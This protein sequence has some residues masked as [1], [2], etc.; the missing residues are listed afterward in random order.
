M[1]T[2]LEA[3]LKNKKSSRMP[4][5]FV[6]HGSPMNIVAD[7]EYTRSLSRFALSLPKPKSILIISAH[8]ETEGSFVQASSRPTIIHDF[9]GFP[10]SLYQTGYESEGAPQLASVLEEQLK[11][12]VSATTNWGLDH[13]AW[14]VLYHMYPEGEIPVSQI[15]LNVN[16][17]FSQHYQLAQELIHLR[18]QEVLII[19]SGNIV[20][21]LRTIQWQED[22]PTADWAQDFDLRVAEA[23]QSGQYE[24]FLAPENMGGADLF[25]K[26]H[27][28]LDHYIPLLYSL[29]ARTEKDQVHWI[30]EGMQN[31]SISMRSLMFSE[32]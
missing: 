12:Q 14:S 3:F 2:A 15:S 9:Y 5:L 7:N 19:A 4:V 32:D 13:G 27:P 29:G 28:S 8:W 26:A 10:A 25:R 20:H 22:A 6:G 31:S 21:N 17:N 11:P 18:D 30:F 1:S 23:L 16:M 24:K